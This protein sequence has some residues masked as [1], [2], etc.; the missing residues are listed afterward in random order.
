MV[1]RLVFGYKWPNLSPDQ[2]CS[3]RSVALISTADSHFL[4]F[5]L[6]SWI[7]SNELTPFVFLGLTSR[8]P[9]ILPHRECGQP[10][11]S[12]PV[13]TYS[14][15][16]HLLH[17]G[18]SQ[19]PTLWPMHRT[20]VRI[21]YSCLTLRHLQI[22]FIHTNSF[23]FSQHPWGLWNNISHFKEENTEAQKN[24]AQILTPQ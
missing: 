23:S 24:E 10:A 2:L 20:K 17:P 8:H 22:T 13:S 5:L 18:S 21:P 1:P 14:A 7:L 12:V 3:F 4:T 9:H 11:L 15:E 16:H 19:R 6:H